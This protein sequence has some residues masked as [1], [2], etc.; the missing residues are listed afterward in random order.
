[1]EKQPAGIFT[2]V[3]ICL[4]TFIFAAG[5]KAQPKDDFKPSFDVIGNVFADYFYKIDGQEV[6]YS[7]L[8][9]SKLPK[10]F[11]AFSFRRAILGGRFFFAKNMTANVFLEANDGVTAPTNDRTLFL[12]IAN[13]EFRE[14]VPYARILAGLSQ[15]ITYAFSSE[16]VWR[17]R[18]VEKTIVDMRGLGAST[19]LGVS[20]IGDF[21][22]SG[23]F[24]YGVMIGNGRGTKIAT[25]KG[26]KFYGNLTGRFAEKKVI[27]DL[28]SDY[29]F[30][31]SEK[32]RVTLK[33][34]IGYNTDDYAAGIEV[35]TQ[36]QKNYVSDTSG[37]KVEVAP[38]GVSVFGSATL[39][40][41]KLRAFA[42]F[43]YF[44]N[45]SDYENGIVYPAQYNYKENFITAGLDFTPAKQVHIMPNVWINTYSDKRESGAKEIATDFVG[46]ITLAYFISN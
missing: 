20:M 17:Y 24:G 28:Y 2:L 19:D 9:Y 30:E 18:S 31:P 43:D 36:K 13:V 21:T 29:S 42:R 34:F 5:I 8:D 14:V 41:E 39:V 45:S 40:K 44:D 12:K 15:S 33:G 38:F 27:V 22:K 6:A 11:Q 32:S 46:R 7:P 3:S 25:N 4:L 37:K 10:D 23:E 1:M 16:P 26:K 35:F